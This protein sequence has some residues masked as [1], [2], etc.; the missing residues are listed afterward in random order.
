[1]SKSLITNLI[2]SIL[3]LVGV[4][5]EWEYQNLTLSIGLFALSGAITNW[6]AI[7]MLFERVPLLYGSGVVTEKFEEFK[8]GIYNLMM[9]EFFTRDNIDKF[10]ERE[11]SSSDKHFDFSTLLEKTDFS[12]AFDALKIAVKE[13]SFGGM[14]SMIGGESALEPLKEPFSIKLKGAMNKIVHSN[15]FQSA[16]QDNLKNSKVSNDILDKVSFIVEQRLD[17]LTPN[18]VKEIIQKMIR[19]HL[20]WLVIWGGVFGGLIGAI[21]TLLQS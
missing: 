8:S 18:M 21:F 9:N 15:T 13:S 16:L 3:V 1:M 5:I 2:A 6:L 12:S 19:E 7:Y 14:L 11:F 10:F 17:E 20:G 4:F